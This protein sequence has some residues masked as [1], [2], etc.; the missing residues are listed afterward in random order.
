MSSNLY[1]VLELQLAHFLSKEFLKYL[2]VY[3]YIYIYI[4]IYVK[5]DLDFLSFSS[6]NLL[7]TKIKKL[8]RTRCKKLNSN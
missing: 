5:L 6:N 8:D 4:Y 7:A 1:R 2:M 3:H